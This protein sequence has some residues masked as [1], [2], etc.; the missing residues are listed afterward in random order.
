MRKPSIALG[1]LVLLT[2]PSALGQIDTERMKPAVTHDGWVNAEGSGVRHP[3][4]PWEFGFFANYGVNPLIIVDAGGDLQRQ[5]VGGRLGMDLLASV[6]LA[7]P[8]ALGL[9]VP[10]FL[11]QSGDQN[12]SFAGLGDVR[13]FGVHAHQGFKDDGIHGFPGTFEL[14]AKLIEHCTRFGLGCPSFSCC[15]VPTWTAQRQ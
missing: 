5:V 2:A 1:A 14:A 4:D 10:F 6:S 11:L 13:T 8:F 9:G 7:K 3:D 12:P 15:E